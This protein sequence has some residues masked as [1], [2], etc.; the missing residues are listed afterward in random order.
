MRLDDVMRH[1]GCGEEDVCKIVTMLDR[2]ISPVHGSRSK[3]SRAGNSRAEK[4]PSYIVTLRK[5]FGQI[6]GGGGPWGWGHLAT[7]VR[8]W[9][10]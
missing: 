7:C 1:R 5:I 4:A 9:R 10:A 3:G 2:T 8:T 6:K